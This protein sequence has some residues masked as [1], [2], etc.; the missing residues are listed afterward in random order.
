[1]PKD[2]NSLLLQAQRNGRD[3]ITPEDI[4]ECLDVSVRVMANIHRNPRGYFSYLMEDFCEVHGRQ[5]PG[6]YAEDHTLCAF[7]LWDAMRRVE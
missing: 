5:I 1:M 6:A 4:K 3:Y 7:L 2:I